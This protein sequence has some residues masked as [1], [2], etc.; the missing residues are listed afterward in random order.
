MQRQFTLQWLMGLVAVCGFEAFLYTS[1]AK[2]NPAMNLATSIT[3]NIS[4]YVFG[5]VLFWAVFWVA[6]SRLRPEALTGPGGA[7]PPPPPPPPPPA[8]M[9]FRSEN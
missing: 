9:P 4:L 1:S 8:R 3:D 7:R 6:S 5:R 2:R